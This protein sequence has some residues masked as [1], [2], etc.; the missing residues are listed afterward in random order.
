MKIQAQ[1]LDS[2][3]YMIHRQKYPICNLLKDKL[4]TCNA[5][6]DSS[7]LGCYAVSTGI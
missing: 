1:S 2:C 4:F 3:Q 5:A 7:L 6:E